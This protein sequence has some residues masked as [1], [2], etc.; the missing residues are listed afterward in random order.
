MGA[1][2]GGDFCAV[3]SCICDYGPAMQKIYQDDYNQ[4]HL[5]ELSEDSRDACDRWMMAMDN[6]AVSQEEQDRLG[7]EYSDAHDAWT[8]LY[9]EI[10]GEPDWGAIRDGCD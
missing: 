3:E 4:R 5:Q 7:S 10:Y 6:P 9:T 2:C 1:P 8:A